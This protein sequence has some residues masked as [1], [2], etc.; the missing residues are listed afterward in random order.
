MSIA[1]VRVAAALGLPAASVA[2]ALMLPVAGTALAVK[3]V[4]QMPLL[5]AVTLCVVAPHVTAT[6][7][8]ASALP[9]TSTPAAFSATLTVLSVA[10]GLMTGV[11]GATASNATVRVLAGPVL[12]ATSVAT[13]LIFPLAGMLALAKVLLQLPSP[14]A[15]TCWVVEPQVTATLAPASAVP[16][17]ATPAAFSAML[18]VP[19]VATRWITGASGAAVS[20]AT[21]R[22]VAG[23]VL[24]AVSITV[25]TMV[26]LPLAGSS[27][28]MKLV[29]QA[30][31]AAVTVCVAAPQTTCTCAPDSAVPLTATPAVFSAALTMLSVATP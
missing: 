18:T 12:P 11:L 24:P 28:P 31:A 15:L 14:A 27:L 17:T 4:L 5:A 25:A 1:M 26:A 13:A 2:T 23:L 16:L 19:S 21:V 3:V 10:T 9:L 22:P 6:L 8:P 7:A 20:K 30:P 29:V